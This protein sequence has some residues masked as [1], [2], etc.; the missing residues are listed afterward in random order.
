MQVT[1]PKK[2]PHFMWWS[3]SF[4]LIKAELDLKHV[5]SLREGR[6]GSEELKLLK[7]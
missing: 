5:V 4:D 6:S 3:F 7:V 2:P 1:S